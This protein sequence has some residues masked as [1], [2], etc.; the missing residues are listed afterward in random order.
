[1][2]IEELFKHYGMQVIRNERSKSE[3]KIVGRWVLI[4]SAQH[5]RQL[6]DYLL[7]DRDIFRVKFLKID[8]ATWTYS[9]FD[10]IA[11]MSCYNVLIL[12][13]L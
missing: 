8:D 1:M 3:Q 4:G 10:N 7:D 5:H 11:L 13:Y 6:T 2:N 12:L 9:R